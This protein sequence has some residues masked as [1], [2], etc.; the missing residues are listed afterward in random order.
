[1]DALWQ[2]V[3]YALSGFRKDPGF[4]M[5]AITALALGIGAATA[6]FSVVDN[7]LLDAWPYRDAERIVA[8]YIHD[9][10]RAR[11][12]G[13][14]AYFT[15]EFMEYR[16]QAQVFEDVVGV[17]GEDVLYSTP[18]GTE[19]LQGA[20][21]TSN[22]FEF[23]GV[24][25]VMGRGIQRED[26]KPGAAPVFVMSYKMWR[27]YF[28]GDPH[29]LGRSFILNGETRTLVGIMPPRFTYF[30]ADLWTPTEPDPADPA[31]RQRYFMLQGRMKPGVTLA[32]VASNFQVIAQRLAKIYPNDYPERFDMRAQSLTDMVVGRF[33][34]TLNI[35]LA[36]V[37]L[38]LF[39]ACANV[40]NMLLA[41]AI[42][43]E[44]EVAVRSALGASRWRVARRLLV[45][46]ALLAAGGAA[47]GCVLAYVGIKAVVGIIPEDSIPSEAVIRMNVPVL[48]FSL[49]IAALTTVLA[50]LAPAIHAARK[51]IVNPLKDAG[52]GV[53]GGFRHGR[54]RSA[55]VIG[56]IALSLVLLT[57]A[58]LLM[59]TMVALQ[60][61]DLGLNP[62]NILV[63]RLPL[64]KERYKSAA[65]K[66]QFFS[67]V[68]QRIRNLPGVVAATETSTLPPY[69]GIGSEVDVPGKTHS[70]KWR[71]IYQLCSEGYFPTLGLK[72][73]RGRV[74]TETEVNAARHVAV[75]NQTLAR[76]FFGN[77]DPIGR[78]VILRDLARATDPVA[79]PVFD[80][81]GV[82]SDAKNQGIQEAPMPEAF[83]PYT[84]TGSYERGVL[85]RTTRDPMTVLNSVRREIWAVDR[86]VALTLTG[87]LKGYL[88]S[89]SYSGPQFTLTILAIFA[90]LG[91]LLVAI[92]AYSV[93]SYTVSRQTHEIGIRMA[94]GAQ[95]SDVFRMILRMGA[96]LVGA[97]LLTGIAASFGVNRLIVTQIW[98][99]RPDDP[100]TISSV[101]V[102]IC[103]V[104]A[105]AC[106]APARRA[107]RVDPVACLRYE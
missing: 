79:N 74:L 25:P 71:A 61:V 56:E 35:L 1:M 47:L 18:E 105:L 38:L 73:V 104:G 43:R 24:P 94:L 45:E 93:I 33:R 32:Q 57:G 95:R 66:Q 41:R 75:V 62:D 76:K 100:V 107:T 8:T 2:D 92:G 68:L 46:S 50:G 86:G 98:G 14:G 106:I 4:T 88:K 7:V 96:I 82:I 29:L 54:L 90:S 19:R 99:V 17:R 13:R 69:G 22:T 9:K 20:V 59:R 31:A 102:I 15:T 44:R 6:I 89:F 11:P 51:Q 37:G 30:G 58:G 67:Q 60:T 49:A 42:T 55:L 21:V 101:A 26:G 34:T 97:G 10:D 3:R 12:G 72:L 87:T 53:S 63:A 78:Q 91:L 36:A 48:L 103:A 77:E 39:I 28:N 16:K 83:I 52:K 5:L 84:V 40:A 70:E 85:V 64:P 65:A 81:V 80:I 27:K 23:L